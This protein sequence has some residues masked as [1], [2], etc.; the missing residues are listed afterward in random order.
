LGG[1]GGGGVGLFRKMPISLADPFLR[2][3]ELA[4][5]TLG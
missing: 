5:F 4:P 1:V 3:G 2:F